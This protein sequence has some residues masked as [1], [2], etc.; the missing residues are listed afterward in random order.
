MREQISQLS[1]EIADLNII[2]PDKYDGTDSQ[3]LQECLNLATA[4]RGGIITL[5]RTYTLTENVYVDMESGESNQIVIQGEGKNAGINF[6]GFCFS[7]R[8]AELG[9]EYRGGGVLFSNVNL[10]GT[11][12]GFDCDQLAR[13]R[14]ESCSISG[15]K[16]LL[17]STTYIQSCYFVNSQIRRTSDAVI[18]C[19]KS[20][21]LSNGGGC[22]DLR[23]N[24][25]I[26]EWCNGLLDVYGLG[27]CSIVNNCIEGFL[28]TPIIIRERLE[29]VAINHNYWEVNGRVN[30]DLSGATACCHASISNNMFTEYKN[31]DV[32]IIHLPTRID[33]GVLTITGNRVN[34]DEVFLYVPDNATNLT[35]VWAFANGGKLYDT[36]GLLR[37]A[38]PSDLYNAIDGANVDFELSDADKAEIV[39]DTLAA[40]SGEEWN[41]TLSDG[42]IFK[43]M[44]ATAYSENFTQE[45]WTFVLAD[46]STIKKVVGTA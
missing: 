5:N 37:T 32:G 33:E 14:F 43:R 22:P 24:N 31:P 19:V 11:N 45:T 3:K 20:D 27:G 7:S 46:G 15:F 13:L 12:I 40:L 41:F 21:T 29:G 34:I 25:C 2:N 18:K 38:T 28:N 42:T 9:L 8:R 23:I 44:I 17:Y 10:T 1:S 30:I 4:N 6:G 26:I 35:N 36:K 16:H 39:D